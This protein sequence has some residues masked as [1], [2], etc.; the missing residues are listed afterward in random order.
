MKV[1]GLSW[2]G[3]GTD[4]FPRT[5]AFFTEVLGLPPAVVDPR[6]VALLHAGPGQLVEIFGPGTGGRALT[7]PPVIAFEVDDVGAARAELAAAG[8]EIIGDI[9]A[10][11]GFEWLYF[12]SPDGHLFSVKKTPPPGW[13]TTG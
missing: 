1:K 6:G 10:W 11:N 9:G 3:V 2:V 7:A 12:R 13:E 4:D 5:L 8:V